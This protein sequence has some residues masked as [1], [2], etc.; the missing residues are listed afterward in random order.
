MASAGRRDT[1]RAALTNAPF[2]PIAP[3]L[4]ADPTHRANAQRMRTEIRA[5]LGPATAGTLLERL[6]VE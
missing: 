6:R 4:V 5:M 1:V 3:A 2:A